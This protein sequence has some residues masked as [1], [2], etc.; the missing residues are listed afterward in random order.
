MAEG[1]DRAVDDGRGEGSE[2][3]F[4]FV[5]PDVDEAVD[6]GVQVEDGAVGVE[7]GGQ[8]AAFGAAADEGVELFF[9]QGD[10]FF[11]HVE[12]GAGFFGELAFEVDDGEEFAVGVV[13]LD[14]L[15]HVVQ[16][17]AQAVAAGFFEAV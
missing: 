1:V 8:F 10:V 11:L 17:A 2:V 9:P 16:H 13:G 5:E 12:Y 4:G 7:G 6:N 15:E 14:A 3:G